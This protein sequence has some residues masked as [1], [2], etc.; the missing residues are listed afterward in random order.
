[1]GVFWAPMTVGSEAWEVI[2]A[3]GLPT[4]N[5]QLCRAKSA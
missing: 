2:T 1:V 3:D 4:Q 5:G